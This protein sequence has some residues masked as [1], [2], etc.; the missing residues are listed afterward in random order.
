MRIVSFL[1]RCLADCAET[2]WTWYTGR[3]MVAFL[4]RNLSEQNTFGKLMSLAT[5]S[6]E[7]F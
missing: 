2:A 7:G 3:R 5:K 1:K 6:S 4:H